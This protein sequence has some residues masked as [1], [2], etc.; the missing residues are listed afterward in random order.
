M[1]IMEINESWALILKDTY[2]LISHN[3][4]TETKELILNTSSQP[5]S[6][7]HIGTVTTLFFN[8]AIAKH[9]QSRSGI[10]A[11]VCF[12]QLENTP[13]R[14]ETVDNDIYLY[15]LDEKE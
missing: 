12:D 13:V 9:F 5:N 2:E 11:S 3:N 10:P 15:Y 1:N 4:F 14:E 7:P 8:F 6:R